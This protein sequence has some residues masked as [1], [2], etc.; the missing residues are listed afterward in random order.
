MRKF[1]VL[2]ALVLV[3]GM[4]LSA[5]QTAVPVV[6]EPPVVEPVAE[7]PEVEEPSGRTCC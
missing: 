1:S 5:C 6:E 7:E 3:L 4:L 2:L